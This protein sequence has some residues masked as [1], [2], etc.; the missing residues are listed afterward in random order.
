MTK[1]VVVYLA[2]GTHARMLFNSLSLLWNNFILSHRYPVIVFEEGDF[3]EEQRKE[4]RMI[5]PGTTFRTVDLSPPSWVDTSPAGRK[6]W[7]LKRF[8]IGYRS[9]CR[10]FSMQV[11]KHLEGEFDYYMRLDDD[12]EVLSPVK[13]DLFRCMEDNDFWYAWRSL[14][15]ENNG[16][17]GLL[18]LIRQHDPA[19]RSLGSIKSVY[20]TNFHMA[21]TDLWS[22]PKIASLLEAID[23]S[24][25]IYKYRWGDHCIQTYICKAYV[26][27]RHVK[28]FREFAYKHGRGTWP[29]GK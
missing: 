5:C 24:G 23:K 25:G 28:L 15:P 22:Q 1:G 9:M 8:G 17:D 2:R 10:F 18:S 11:F 20:Y 12:S 13:T 14:W 7:A 16:M 19:L 27:Q 4:A 29:A 21:K 3:T 6:T 26:P